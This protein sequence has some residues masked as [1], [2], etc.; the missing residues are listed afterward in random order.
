MNKEK[1]KRSLNSQSLAHSLPAADF[2]A[3]TKPKGFAT[4]GK[5]FIY[6]GVFLYLVSLFSKVLIFF[7]EEQK[8]NFY[9]GSLAFIFFG[10]GGYFYFSN[11]EK[12]PYKSC[13]DYIKE[14]RDYVYLILGFFI[15]GAVLGAVF[16]DYLAVILKKILLE[17][18]ERTRN[19]SALDLTFFIFN[20]NVSSSLFGL[21]FG[22]FLGIFPIFTALLNGIVLGFVL[23]LS[24]RI[25][26]V[27]DF[28][29][30]LPHG[31]FELTA[32]FISLGL[33]IKLGMFLFSKDI[34]KEFRKRFYESI[35]VFLL[36]VIPLLLLA[37]IIEAILI[38]LRI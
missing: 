29:R 11:S 30:I 23:S 17:L 27:A 12:K 2:L 36:I 6:G 13:F 3:V 37:A 33:G 16:S 14:S 19:L 22:I 24:W 28:W 9:V 18:V 32:V 35:K 38:G 5:S 4:L 7:G 25:S 21:L 8:F 31:I 20:N 15:F 26:G 1:F 34:K 10:I